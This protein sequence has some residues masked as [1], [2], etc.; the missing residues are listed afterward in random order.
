MGTGRSCTIGQ[1]MDGAK[2]NEKRERE[3]TVPKE[4]SIE[5]PGSVHEVW[6]GWTLTM[7]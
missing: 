6:I 7:S 2:G 1:L 4:K 5:T 3:T